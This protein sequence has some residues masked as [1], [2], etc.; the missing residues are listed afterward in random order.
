[1][2]AAQREVLILKAQQLRLTARE[3]GWSTDAW[4]LVRAAARI[5][6]DEALQREAASTLAGLDANV[7]KQLPHG[8]SSVAWDRDGKRLLMGGLPGQVAR[9]WDRDTGQ[10][11][12]SQH[13]GEGLV[14]FG[15]DGTPLQ[16]ILHPKAPDI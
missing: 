4:A 1:A 2:N 3:A 7:R 6:A 13:G 5:R 15:E 16:L 10:V 11:T 8:A 9:L 12:D 14:A